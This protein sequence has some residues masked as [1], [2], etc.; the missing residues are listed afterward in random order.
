MGRKKIDKV[1]INRERFN[2]ALK[3]KGLSINKLDN[4][5]LIGVTE[6]TIRRA[7]KNH[8]INPV[9][10]EKIGER[11]DVDTYWL[12]G[13][14][15][16]WISL[17]MT[18]INKDKILDHIKIE[19]NPYNKNKYERK[20]ID[21]KKHFEETLILNGISCN[22][23]NSL[24]EPMQHGFEMELNLVTQM[25]VFKYFSK[26]AGGNNPFLSNS[27]LLKMSEEVLSGETYEK[28]LNILER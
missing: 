2:E 28:M 17:V 21:F 27:E 5:R 4:D 16:E 7:L 24:P 1:S 11:L 25:V 13:K 20:Q 23:F 10:L 3:R 26:Q 6:K 9:I 14:D 19:N 18:K 12:M 15:L 8:E 22:D